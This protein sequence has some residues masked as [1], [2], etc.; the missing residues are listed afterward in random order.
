MYTFIEDPGHGWLKVPREELKQLDIEDKITSYSYMD[1]EYAYL[2]EDIDADV[3][4]RAKYPN[5]YVARRRF[6]KKCEIE[7][8]EPD[9]P[10]RKLKNFKQ[11]KAEKEYNDNE[12][13]KPRIER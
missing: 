12:S 2:E 4:V 9:A 3:F 6:Y 13:K 10:C 7:H 5:D 1:S 11:S 8:Y